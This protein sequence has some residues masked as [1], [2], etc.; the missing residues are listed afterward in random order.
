MFGFRFV[1]ALVLLCSSKVPGFIVSF[2]SIFVSQNSFLFWFL[3][4][5]VL[6]VLV[7][8]LLVLGFSDFRESERC[9]NLLINGDAGLIGDR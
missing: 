3:S 9:C 1:A 6:W 5:F 4:L 8:F 2:A 7:S